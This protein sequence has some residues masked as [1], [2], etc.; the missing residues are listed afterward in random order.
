MKPYLR[1]GGGAEGVGPVVHDAVCA[2]EVD[3]QLVHCRC[4][5]ASADTVCSVVFADELGRDATLLPLAAHPTAEQ[6]LLSNARTGEV[7]RIRLR[8]KDA[9]VRAL[10]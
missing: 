6:A 7:V 1:P 5:A 10:G 3:G 8:C 9:F 4:F 2:R